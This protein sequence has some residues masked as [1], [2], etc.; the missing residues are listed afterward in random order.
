MALNLWLIVA[1]FGVIALAG[2]QFFGRQKRKPLQLACFLPQTQAETLFTSVATLWA[3]NQGGIHWP[4]HWQLVGDVAGPQMAFQSAYW[5]CEQWGYG[6]HKLLWG[7][8]KAVSGEAV[9]VFWLDLPQASAAALQEMAD[10]FLQLSNQ[11]QPARQ[12][13]VWG[14]F[15]PENRELQQYLLLLGLH[16]PALE[17]ELASSPPFC[18]HRGFSSFHFRQFS[19]QLVSALSVSIRV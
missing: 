14:E 3:G 13:V 6:P 10:W 1:L 12:W 19:G 8:F 5:R 17:T 7:H 9:W 18:Y 11:W 15:S 4:A 2:F 16:N